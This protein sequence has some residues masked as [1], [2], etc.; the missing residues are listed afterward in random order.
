VTP[1]KAL[2]WLQSTTEPNRRLTQARI[3]AYAR[4]MKT[5][6]WHFN[7]EPIR[8]NQHGQ[9]LDGQHRCWA[10]AESG[11][12]NEFLIIKGLPSKVIFI[13]DTG[14]ARSLSQ[15]LSIK[16]ETEVSIISTAVICHNRWLTSR[17]YNQL[18]S[19][20]APTMQDLLTVHEKWGARL[21][22]QLP[23]ARRFKAKKLGS[24]GLWTSLLT[25]LEGIHQEDK[26]DFSEKLYSGSSLEEG[27]PILSLKHRIENART[28][29][30]GIS[31]YDLA[32]IAIKAWN[33][34][35]TGQKTLH[36]AFRAG[37]AHPEIYPIPI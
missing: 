28:S 18:N 1:E 29:R 20:L 9:L 12:A 5:D 21:S 19:Q 16:G 36:L 27:H 4:E 25:V 8:F 30:G 22:K 32:P 13:T 3:T 34:Y 24:Q 10:I 37:G 31:Q 35:R 6:A 2:A 15:F 7:G 33:L 11:I 23:L 26:E 14:Q 17:M